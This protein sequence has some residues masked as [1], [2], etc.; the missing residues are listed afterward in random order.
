MKVIFALLLAAFTGARPAQAPTPVTIALTIGGKSY[1][2]KGQGECTYAPVGSIYGVRASRWSVQYS[3]GAG[4]GLRSMSLTLWHPLAGATA[5]QMS[6]A[7]SVGASSYRIDTVQGQGRQ[8]VGAGTVRVQQ[9][10]M[11]GRLEVD[12]KDT[13]G[14]AI[15]G[16][17]ECARWASPEAVAG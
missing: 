17:V 7:A 11:G 1:Q 5:D 6:F 4:A 3:G 10:G 12:G 9:K 8:T 15:R 2:A 13:K 16:S 14:T